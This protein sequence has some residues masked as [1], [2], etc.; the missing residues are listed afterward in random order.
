MTSNDARSRP[1]QNS[2]RDDVCSGCGVA[3]DH[4]H[5]LEATVD[6]DPMSLSGRPTPG[7][8]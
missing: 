5:E 4:G 7:S 1:V 3:N 6:A 8:N 2:W